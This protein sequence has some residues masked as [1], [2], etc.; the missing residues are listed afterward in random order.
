MRCRHRF[1]V[2][3]LISPGEGSSL[4]AR[5]KKYWTRSMK[6][7]VKDFETKGGAGHHWV[8]L[9]NTEI[10]DYRI[11]DF[12]LILGRNKEEI[13]TRLWVFAQSGQ[14]SPNS[15]W[16]LSNLSAVPQLVSWNRLDNEPWLYTMCYLIYLYVW[17][18]CFVLLFV[19]SETTL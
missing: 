15:Q 8:A 11:R 13:L 14:E 1:F 9:C 10:Q 12:F 16:R 3:V 4:T 6:E 2:T 17:V 18:L 19:F 7:R 5:V